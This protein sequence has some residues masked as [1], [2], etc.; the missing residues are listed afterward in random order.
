MKKIQIEI[1]SSYELDK[2]AYYILTPTRFPVYFK[3][4]KTAEKVVRQLK[5]TLSDTI[6]IMSNISVTL[7]QLHSN[8]YYQLHDLTSSQILN[9]IHNYNTQRDFVFKEFGRGN[10]SIALSKIYLL[11]DSLKVASD[12]FQGF[13]K[14]KH[15]HS[16]LV[17]QIN[18]I[19]KELS[20]L[21]NSLHDELTNMSNSHLNYRKHFKIVHKKQLICQ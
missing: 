1:L 5:Q 11:F 17:V 4:K 3:N 9:S 21:R 14:S 19:L 8:Y 2:G 6:S 7:Y 12:L 15:S 18:S 10:Q 16:T 13:A 20:L